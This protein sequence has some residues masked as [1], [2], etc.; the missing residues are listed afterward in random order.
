MRQRD[1]QAVSCIVRVPPSPPGHPSAAW[2]CLLAGRLDGPAGGYQII[3]AGR[4]SAHPTP[5]ANA[6]QAHARR[7][8]PP[9]QSRHGPPPTCPGPYPAPRRGRSSTRSPVTA[10]PGG[11]RPVRAPVAVPPPGFATSAPP[12]RHDFL[13]P[14]RPTADYVKNADVTFINLESPLLAGCSTRSTGMVFC[15]D[16]RFVD[17]LTAIGTKGANLANNHVYE[18]PH[19]QA[20]AALRQ[21]H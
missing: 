3:V 8:V 4:C 12:T 1:A 2:D 15:G 14:F 6:I 11:V 9:E 18:G 21:Q 16:T 10:A 17:G 5:H 7:A 20:T 19:T 13:W